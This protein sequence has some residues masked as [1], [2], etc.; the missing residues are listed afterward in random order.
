MRL[1]ALYLGLLREAILENKRRESPVGFQLKGTGIIT[2][3]TDRG[4]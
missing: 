4:A 1:G 3:L 2:P